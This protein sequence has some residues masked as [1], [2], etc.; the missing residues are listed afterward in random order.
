M[1]LTMMM[2]IVSDYSNSLTLN[3][4][5]EQFEKLHEQ[6]NKEEYET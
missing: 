2:N 5:A 4:W 6:L 3:K 1:Y